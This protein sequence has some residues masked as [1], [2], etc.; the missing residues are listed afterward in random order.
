MKKIAYIVL[1]GIIS[2]FVSCKSLDSIYEEYIVPNGLSYPAIALDAEAHPGNKRIEIAWRNGAD[3]KV[4][5]ARISWNNDTE[6]T[7]IDNITPE[8]DVISRIIEPLE[9]DTYTFMIRTYDAKGNVSVPVEV[10][11]AVYGE[12]YGR[13]LVNRSVKSALYDNDE[14]VFQLEWNSA[15]ATEVGIELSYTDV[16]GSSRTLPVDP[17]ETAATIS[18]LKVGEPVFY[19]TAY[20]PDSLAIDVFYAPKVQIPY[21]ADITEMVLKNCEAPFELGDIIGWDRFIFRDLKYWTADEQIQKQGATDNVS[22]FAFFVY[23]GF[24]NFYSPLASLTNAKLY[25]TV[26]LEAGTYKFNVFPLDVVTAWGTLADITIAANVGSNLPDVDNLDQAL[27]YTRRYAVSTADMF[28]V[29]FNVPEKS[30]V[31]I[32][33][34]VNMGEGYLNFSKV[35]LFKEF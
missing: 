11:G 29:T 26:E 9:E 18:D 14:S 4:T 25:Q 31:S 21:Y 13:S 20:K 17:S 33:F 32:G 27:N 8:M 22:F 1:A 3:P 12:L 7:E 10:T 34:I 6:W 35:E 15:D 5:K 2:G 23:N 19:T 24:A 30:F 28:S 16:S